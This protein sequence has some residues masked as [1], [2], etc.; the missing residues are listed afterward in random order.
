MA[1]HLIGAG[2][3]QQRHPLQ[4][5]E[6]ATD[7]IGTG[8]QQE[9]LHIED[10]CRLVRPFNQPAKP[11]E[12]PGEV[13][14]QRGIRDPIEELTTTANLP[15]LLLGWFLPE[16]LAFH[17]GP[18]ETVEV[19]PHLAGD[20]IPDLPGV[21]PGHGDAVDDAARVG[22]RPHQELDHL[23]SPTIGVHRIK[24]GAISTG[25]D[26]GLPR[27]CTPRRT[28]QGHRLTDLDKAG[29]V[30]RPL[31]I[32][33]NPIQGVGNTAQH[34]P[35]STIQVSLH[36]PPWEE[37]TTSDPRLRATRVKPPGVTQL[38]LPRRM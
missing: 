24:E 31:D 1:E 19:L 32:A 13:T 28:V 17:Q 12:L 14:A 6:D 11:A 9:I 37:F 15:Q 7:V 20:H 5:V 36:P 26:Q 8:Q 34:W 21:L 22:L 16:L 38:L 2:T 35:S 4:F 27:F 23:L 29:D 30:L 10:A 33:V 3:A 18:V 25:I